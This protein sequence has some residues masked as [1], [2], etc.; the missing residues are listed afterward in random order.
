MG[1]RTSWSDVRATRCGRCVEV[2]SGAGSV[3][4]MSVKG[5]SWC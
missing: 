2:L 3:K 5:L 1:L 4:G